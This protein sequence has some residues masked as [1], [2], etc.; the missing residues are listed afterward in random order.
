LVYFLNP[1][2]S[3]LKCAIQFFWVNTPQNIL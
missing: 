3:S 2:H 1:L